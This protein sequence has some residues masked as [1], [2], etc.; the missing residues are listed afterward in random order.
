MKIKASQIANLTDARYFAAK[1]VEW[2]SFNFVEDTEAYIQP[3]KAATI[4]EWVAGVQFIAET[5]VFSL[6]QI[7]LLAHKYNIPILQ[8]DMFTQPVQ[9][10]ELNQ[11]FKIIKEYIIEKNDT[12]PIIIAALNQFKTLVQAFQ[13]DFEKNGV[14]W[15]ALK[16][17]SSDESH[18]LTAKDL[19]EI[20]TQFPIIL[21]IEFHHT[22]LTEIIDSINPHAINL[23][24]G[25]EEK[26]GIKSY[27]ELDE[28]LEILNLE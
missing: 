15:K 21:N 19:K 26:T 10:I 24:G 11:D 18:Q 16:D 22:E 27:E 20:C 5:N 17:R 1:E 13:L 3:I 14:S 9:I 6:N 25:E 4:M 28:I 8:V 2:L 12:A 7:A 23:K